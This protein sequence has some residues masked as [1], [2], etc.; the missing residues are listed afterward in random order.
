MKQLPIV[1]VPCNMMEYQGS[2][3]HFVRQTYVRALVKVVKCVPLLIPATGDGFRLDSLAGRIDGVLL[4]GA[5]SNVCPDHYS[6][7]R[8]FDEDLL[9]TARDATTL[10]LIR[11]AIAMDM[12]LF[13]V[14]RGFQEMNV[15]LGGSLHQF[16]H[17]QPGKHDHRPKDL[18]F[19]E[20][21][22]HQTHKVDVRKGGIFEKLKLPASFTV[23]SIHNQGVDRL[24]DGLFVEAVAED[25]LVEA[26]SIPG[27]RFILGTQW[28]PE[29]DYWLNEADRI[30][31]E[32]FGS[33]LH[34]GR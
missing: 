32:S 7:T 18:P 25:G 23:N 12:P 14:C 29:G 24:A 4:T 10:P 16:V 13:A 2:R 30:L 27:K 22:E 8:E 17:K 11:D 28:H 31:L 20:K 33:I 3:V 19:K 9:D 5:A 34:A 15:A 26:V 1:A 6:G 21:Y